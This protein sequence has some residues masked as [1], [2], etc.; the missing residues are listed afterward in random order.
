MRPLVGILVAVGFL[1]G[2]Y[3]LYLKRMPSTDPGTV[4]VQAISLSGVRMD[5]LQIAQAERTNLAT[6]GRCAS[7]D[8]LISANAL[9]MARPERDGYTYSVDCSG[10]GF[11]ITASHAPAPAGSAFRYPT[12]IIDQ[13]MQFREVQ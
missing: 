10:A 9:S 13:N 11:A 3:L 6:N 8:E 5:L 4:S 7:L 2:V 12:L 1:F